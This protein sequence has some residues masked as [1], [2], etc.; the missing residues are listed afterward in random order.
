MKKILVLATLLMGFSGLLNMGTAL[1][2]TAQESVCT[3]IGLAADG[4]GNCAEPTGG[5]VSNIITNAIGVLSSIVGVVAVVMV[6]VGGFKYVTS[7][8]DS[9]KVSSAKSTV[10]YA[11]IGLVIVAMSQ[12][13]IHFVLN[14]ATTD[15]PAASTKTTTKAA[16]GNPAGTG[17]GP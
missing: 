9:N 4:S 2:A 14:K 17:T 8:G 3:G 6:V 7:G 10:M 11:L 12:V 1:A 13:I 5:G 16:P 15:T